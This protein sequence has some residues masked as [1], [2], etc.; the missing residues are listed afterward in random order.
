MFIV[1]FALER[2]AYIVCANIESFTCVKCV[3][4]HNKHTCSVLVSISSRFRGGRKGMGYF[5]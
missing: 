3:Q 2:T 5:L 4:P 1:D